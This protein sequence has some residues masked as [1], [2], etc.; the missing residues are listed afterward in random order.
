[1]AKNRH[2]FVEAVAGN[3]LLIDQ[4]KADLLSASLEHIIT[5]ADSQKLLAASSRMSNFWADGDDCP[6]RPYAVADG[7]LQIPVQGVLLNRFSYAFGRWATGYSYIEQALIRGLAD[8]NVRAIALVC[9]S[10]GGEVAGC[11]ELA[12]KI[13]AGRER[14][15]IRA[16][17]ADHA[18]SAAYALA[19]SA[20]EIVVT[21]SGGTGSIG[22]VMAHYDI[23]QAM[24]AA[25]VKITFVFAGEHKV[26]GNSVQP[27]PDSV[28][29][30]MQAKVDKTYNLFV[31]TVARNRGMEDVKVRDTKALTFDAED[32]ITEGLADR[33][34][35]LEDEMAVFV[36][37]LAAAE[38]EQMTTT[39]TQEALDT[40]V[41]TAKAEARA[42]GKAEGLK[43]GATAERTRITAILAS[44]EGK[45][46]PKAAMSL[47]MKTP[48][49]LDEAKAALGEM[50][51][52]KAETPAATGTPFEQAMGNTPNPAVGH[53]APAAPGG[54]EAS[55][56]DGF[57]GSFSGAK[58]QSSAAA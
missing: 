15:P 41:A 28:K 10:P 2:P 18:Y 7:V 6:W 52:E 37:E 11:F 30:R 1:M 36:S 24:D 27:L 58:P 51:E 9:D 17:A 48:L 20:E 29:A 34:G 19:S 49:S 16:F 26:D 21:R 13:F 47:A 42:E 23:S 33:I 56:T 39:I 54:T 32:S 55:F 38:D 12:D 44:D 35:A 57:F 53:Q 40:A 25:G 4:T 3:P 45:K 43:E 8:A 46:R 5:D 14:K 31:S 50:P 22:V